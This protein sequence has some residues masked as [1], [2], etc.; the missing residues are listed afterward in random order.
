METFVLALRGRL[1]RLPRD[2]GN[3]ERGHVGGQLS[4]PPAPGRVQRG[5]VVGEQTLRN[6]MR[7]DA[8][9]HHG[10]STLGGLTGRDI[11]GDGEAGVVV[12]EL[13]DHTLPPGG[14]DV[15]GGVELPARVRCRVDE[16]AIRRARLL[17]RLLAGD[18]G[19]T[20]DARQRRDRRGREAERDHLVVDTDRA[21]IQARGFQRGPHLDRLLFHLVDDRA[22][23]GLRTPGLGL[24]HR[25][26]AL[27]DRAGAERVERAAGDV[28]LGAER[29]HAAARSIVGPTCDRETD[30]GI[31]G[32]IRFRALELFHPRSVHTNEPG[33]VRDDLIPECPRS[34]ET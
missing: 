17:P 11:G 33:S 24:Q 27:L 23:A 32:W 13:E 22:R 12:L 3:A 14:E 15:L 2:R 18:P 1:A 21:V 26:L 19:L 7:G 25:G 31:N 29:G 34:P 8:L 9:L 16:P 6:P 30:T 28:L 10:E 20:E 5:T 4:L